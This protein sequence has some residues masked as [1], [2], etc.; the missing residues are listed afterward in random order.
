MV[1]IYIY[2]STLK[3]ICYIFNSLIF[4]SRI[5]YRIPN[6]AAAKSGYLS[7]FTVRLYMHITGCGELASEGAAK[8][9]CCLVYGVTEV[10]SWQG[11][12]GV[13]G[14]CAQELVLHAIHHERRD[15]PAS[16]SSLVR[17]SL[18]LGVIVA[19]LSLYLRSF[20]T[21]TT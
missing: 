14:V 17:Q 8:G 21:R 11:W 16:G 7:A 5:V 15:L 2:I 13:E 12:S 10:G 18:V 20:A 4:R 19:C 1:Y 6:L 9:V 3:L